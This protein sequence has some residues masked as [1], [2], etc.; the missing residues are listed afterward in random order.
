MIF[1]RFAAPVD[2]A[3][4]GKC[5][6][7]RTGARGMPLPITAPVAV[8][9]AANSEVVPVADIVVRT[10]FRVTRTHWQKRLCT[11]QR[12]HLALFVHTQHDGVFRRSH[13]QPHHV[14]HF[15]DK[16]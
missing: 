8:S 2:M 1:S 9:N 7:A 15:F 13:V 14:A 3:T 11:I 10:L 6:G 5:G 12:L 16:V 4:K